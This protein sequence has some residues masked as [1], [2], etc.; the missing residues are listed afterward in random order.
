MMRG[1]QVA[2]DDQVMITMDSLETFEEYLSPYLRQK[3]NGNRAESAKLNGRDRVN[4]G[5]LVSYSMSLAR[6]SFPVSS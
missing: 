3:C 2:F 4:Q 6:S 1:K 5:N